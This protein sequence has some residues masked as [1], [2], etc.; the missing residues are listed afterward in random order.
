MAFSWKGLGAMAAV[1]GAVGA[2]I[3]G[4]INASEGGQGGTAKW[5]GVG[6]AG[7][8][9]LYLSKG[10]LKGFGGALNKLPGVRHIDDFATKHTGGGFEKMFNAQAKAMGQTPF[11]F[12]KGLANETRKAAGLKSGRFTK[13]QFSE[14]Q[15]LGAQ[16]GKAG[17]RAPLTGLAAGAAYGA[18]SDD[19]SVLGGAFKGAVAGTLG[20]GFYGMNRAYKMGKIVGLG[21][22]H[23]AKFAKDL[24]TATFDAAKTKFKK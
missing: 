17:M 10:R 9:A 8:A 11:G 16:M 2:S 22:N 6:A 18:V 4:G 5:A 24:A 7:A 20:A 19:T 14:F 12:F 15:K 3:K 21:N 13:A 1:G 23:M